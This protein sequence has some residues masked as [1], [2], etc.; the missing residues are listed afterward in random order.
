MSRAGSLMFPIPEPTE[1]VAPPASAAVQGSALNP[2]GMVS[3]TDTPSAVAGPMLATTMAYWNEA[4]ASVVPPLVSLVVA[5]NV[6]PVRL[7]VTSTDRSAPATTSTAPI[8]HSVLPGRGRESSR[9]SVT[10]VPHT[11]TEFTESGS[12]ITPAA[13]LDDVGAMVSVAPPLFLSKPSDA[14]RVP[15]SLMLPGPVPKHVPL[16]SML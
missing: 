6:E 1:P 4:P 16:S 3:A 15:E 11:D 8:V 9:W 5:L 14:S 12:G 2:A 10:P 7:S 13:G